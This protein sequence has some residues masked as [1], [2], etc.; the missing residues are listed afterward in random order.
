MAKHN[1][2]GAMGEKIAVSYLKQ[3]GYII[4]NTN[5]RAGHLE[6]DIVAEHNNEMVFIEVKT[7]SNTYSGLPEEAVDDEKIQLLFHAATAY[8]NKINL[9]I[10]ARFDI[11]GVLFTDEKSSITH[12]EDAFHSMTFQSYN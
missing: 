9:P 7:R 5:W 2:L 6:L 11:I 1:E 10:S 8:L 4:Y 3:K 12:Y